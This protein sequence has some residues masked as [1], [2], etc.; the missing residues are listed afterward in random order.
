MVLLRGRKFS[1]SS[2]RES[3]M[4]PSLIETIS[5]S[6]AAEE[7]EPLS[8]HN[9]VHAER[10]LASARPITPSLEYGDAHA[11]TR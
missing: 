6:H 9:P 3:G 2:P 8:S 5:S 4:R 1:R 11:G 10:L 7:S